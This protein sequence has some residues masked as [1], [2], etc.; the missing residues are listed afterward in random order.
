MLPGPEEKEFWRVVNILNQKRVRDPIGRMRVQLLTEAY[1]KMFPDEKPVDLDRMTRGWPHLLHMDSV[2]P[3]VVQLIS[4]SRPLL[5]RIS[6][7]HSTYYTH[8]PIPMVSDLMFLDQ[9]MDIL[10]S[11]HSPV[12]DIL[13]ILCLVLYRWS[14]ARWAD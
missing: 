1:S 2:D 12:S 10:G 11:L 14:K 3:S 6:S 7:N 4:L 5:T 8:I 13:L 9:I